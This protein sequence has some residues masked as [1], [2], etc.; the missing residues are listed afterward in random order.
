V[1]FHRVMNVP[2][3]GPQ[4]KSPCRGMEV[5]CRKPSGTTPP[6]QPPVPTGT[7]LNNWGRTTPQPGFAN[8]SS[9]RGAPDQIPRA[10]F[11]LRQRARP[12]RFRSSW[13][14]LRSSSVD[15]MACCSSRA[16]TLIALAF[17]ASSISRR[18]DAVTSGH[19]LRAHHRLADWYLFACSRFATSGLARR[20]ISK[21]HTGVAFWPFSLAAGGGVRHPLGRP[22]CDR[23]N[24][25]SREVCRSSTS[26][27]G[28]S[29]D[30]VFRSFIS[31]VGDW[32]IVGASH[33]LRVLSALPRT[34]ICPIELEKAPRPSPAPDVCDLNSIRISSSTR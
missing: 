20:F 3:I 19:G 31:T 12:L 4:A 8:P 26:A 17:A 1:A 23:R 15:A 6:C 29:L 24:M 34:G 27:E 22:P 13:T 7:Q 32:V 30:D 25:P 9:R 33:G 2:S 18:P 10:F 28:V 21:G 16:W 14:H 11:H 5:S